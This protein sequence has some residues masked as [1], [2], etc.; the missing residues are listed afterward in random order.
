MSDG[1]SD[2]AR[3]QDRYFDRMRERLIEEDLV[4]G[5]YNPEV[6]PNLQMVEDPFCV[7]GGRLFGE[8]GL[9]W[10]QPCH[11]FLGPWGAWRAVLAEVNA[12]TRYAVCV[13]P[14]NAGHRLA[15]RGGSLFAGHVFLDAVGWSP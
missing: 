1:C 14:E 12:Y 9:M 6:C 8:C 5:E 13:E 3:T 7:P 15:A 10:C 2:A 4:Y 11:A